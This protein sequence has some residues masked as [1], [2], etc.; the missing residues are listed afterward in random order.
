MTA[1]LIS[2]SLAGSAAVAQGVTNA[3]DG[4]GMSAV[5]VVTSE[6]KKVR[7]YTQA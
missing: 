5:K 7:I 2:M 6:N 4:S 1:L 3:N